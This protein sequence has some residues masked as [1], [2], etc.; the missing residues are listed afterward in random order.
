LNEV[1]CVDGLALGACKR[2]A[3]QMGDCMHHKK[4]FLEFNGPTAG[5]AV[6]YLLL[7]NSCATGNWDFGGKCLV[8]QKEKGL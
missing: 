3:V 5:N 2:H 7:P 8:T 4:E 1:H 6:S